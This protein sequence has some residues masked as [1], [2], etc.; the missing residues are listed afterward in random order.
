VLAR[1][2]GAA[3]RYAFAGGGAMNP[4]LRAA[5]EA[6]LGVAV[7]VPEHPQFLV[8]LGAALSA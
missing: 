8:A 1:Q 4:A 2:V 3:R 6:R 7:D 5:I